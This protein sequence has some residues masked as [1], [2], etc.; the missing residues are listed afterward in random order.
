MCWFEL[1]GGGNF[2]FLYSHS[3]ILCTCSFSLPFLLVGEGRAGEL[4]RHVG[5]KQVASSYTEH[6]LMMLPRLGIT[7]F[8][9]V[10]LSFNW[11]WNDQQD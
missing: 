11:T 3:G 10:Y 5:I 2:F 1:S 8:S 4:C 9:D 6:P 7:I